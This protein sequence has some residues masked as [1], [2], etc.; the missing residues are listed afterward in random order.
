MNLAALYQLPP[1][2]LHLSFMWP[3]GQKFCLLLS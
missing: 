2:G 1:V 3:F